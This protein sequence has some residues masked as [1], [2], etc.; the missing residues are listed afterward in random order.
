M[1]SLSKAQ[2]A[3]MQGDVAMLEDG[4]KSDFHFTAVTGRSWT[5][6]PKG[7]RRFIAG[8]RKE[9]EDEVDLEVEPHPP[10]GAAHS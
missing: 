6:D 5:I 1:K 7:Y 2:L 9:F 4:G 3:I 10:P 8:K